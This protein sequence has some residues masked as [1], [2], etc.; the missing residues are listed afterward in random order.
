ML[1][2]KIDRGKFW[3]GAEWGKCGERGSVGSEGE[4]MNTN[5]VGRLSLK[6]VI[7]IEEAI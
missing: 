6:I 7:S 3:V 2:Y 4:S 1:I 5:L